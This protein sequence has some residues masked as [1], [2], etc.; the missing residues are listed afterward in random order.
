MKKA[1][2]LLSTLFLFVSCKKEKTDPSEEEQTQLAKDETILTRETDLVLDDVNDIFTTSSF[3]DGSSSSLCGITVDSS[4]IAAG[5]IILHYNE[6]ALCV[7]GSRRRSGTVEARFLPV[8]G[9]WQDAG[10]S[11]QI[12]FNNYKVTRVRDDKSLTLNGTK[13]IVNVSGGLIR[14]LTALGNPVIHAVRSDLRLTFDDGT[15]RSWKV[16]RKKTMTVS[17]GYFQL[18]VEGDTSVGGHELVS[19]WGTTRKGSVFYV[20]LEAPLVASAR[21]AWVPISGTQKVRTIFR[22]F[23]VVYGVDENGTP[24]TN[25]PYGYK[26]E[27]TDGNGKNREKTLEYR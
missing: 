22:E 12:L 26:V 9:H 18:S 27:W 1:V 19:T 15:E 5:K 2:F 8:G 21:C 16:A 7:L 20:S 23:E 11:I 24:T 10:S 13:K 6:S 4:Q 25:C 14:K 3:G 17:G